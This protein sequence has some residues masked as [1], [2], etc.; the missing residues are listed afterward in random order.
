[1]Q[2]RPDECRFL[3]FFI[4]VCLGLWYNELGSGWGTTSQLLKV[5]VVFYL[6]I[7]CVSFLIVLSAESPWGHTSI[8]GPHWTFRRSWGLGNLREFV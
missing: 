2:F 5:L 8:D 3:C 6:L 1:M 4:F 7:D